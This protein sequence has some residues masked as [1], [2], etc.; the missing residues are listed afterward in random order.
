MATY[1]VDASVILTWLL[2]DPEVEPD[3]A[4]ATELMASIAR[5]EHE[6]MQP[7]HWLAEV[8]AVLARLSPASA[9][10]DVLQLRAMEWAVLDDVAVWT[11]AVQ[12]ALDTKQHVFDTL[13][14][15]VALETRDAVL[16]TADQ[17]YLQHAGRIGRIVALG[18]IAR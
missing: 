1:V 16:I 11:R 12:L 13:Y 9:A 8:T 15:A 18:V 7:V 10:D 14:H 4:Q 6:I 3:T 5:G 2:A 17:R